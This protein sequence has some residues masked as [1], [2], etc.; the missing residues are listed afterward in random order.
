LQHDYICYKLSA[1]VNESK[2]MN[3]ADK[4]QFLKQKKNAAKSKLGLS[5]FDKVQ[6]STDKEAALAR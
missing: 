2:T 5:K 4:S 1:K 6:L 3:Y